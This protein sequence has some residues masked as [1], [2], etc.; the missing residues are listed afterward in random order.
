MLIDSRAN[1]ASADEESRQGHNKTHTLLEEMLRKPQA[2]D[3][4]RSIV[5]DIRNILTQSGPG[6]RGASNSAPFV[7]GP[8]SS[9]PVVSAYFLNPPVGEPVDPFTGYSG[10]SASVNMFTGSVL[11]IRPSG[12]TIV[13]TTSVGLAA[14]APSPTRS[15]VQ[16][17]QNG[18]TNV[19]LRGDLSQATQDLN[20]K[21]R[22]VGVREYET[23]KQRHPP[24]KQVHKPSFL[25]PT[26][27]S[28]RELHD[29]IPYIFTSLPD[30]KQQTD[31]LKYE[32]ERWTQGLSCLVRDN[33]PG[34]E[35]DAGLLALLA[36]LNQTVEESAKSVRRLFYDVS[37][38]VGL[39]TI[40]DQILIK[41]K[42]VRV[43]KEIEEF[44]DAKEEWEDDSGH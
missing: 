20:A 2:D 40:L 17:I 39:S 22:A 24:P 26:T 29:C 33:K 5:E 15:R 10:H 12:Q 18:Q 30:G 19:I 16:K 7:A 11:P 31:E 43:M 44:Q 36:T 4:L 25:K 1:S 6:V 37:E 3:S 27:P 38:S 34:A 8:S 13:R 23:F 35:S 21:R 14:D 41:S 9:S 32:I 42:S 28:V